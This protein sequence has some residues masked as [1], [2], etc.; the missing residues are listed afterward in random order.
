MSHYEDAV[1]ASRPLLYYALLPRWASGQ[2][3]ITDLTGQGFD[4]VWGTSTPTYAPSGIGDRGSGL[5]FVDNSGTRYIAIPAGFV[6]PAS[7]PISVEIW[8][9]VPVSATK[10]ATS[11]FSLRDADNP[12][13]QCHLPYND[14]TVYWDYGTNSTNRRLSFAGLSK[15]AS[16][17]WCHW[18]FTAQTGLMQIFLNGRL[19]TSVAHSDIPSVTLSGG[20]IGSSAAGAV[21]DTY[22]SDHF[23]VYKR[24]LAQ[25]EILEHYN[26]GLFK[27]HVVSFGRFLAATPTSIK[28]I[29]G[30]SKSSVKTVDGL[31]IDSVK[32]WVGLP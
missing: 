8:R 10:A 15:V 21:N 30:L 9:Y 16:G 13:C 4:A 25:E 12:R 19:L 27:T 14:D 32:T 3:T 18:V 23:A 5:N 20:R 29:D 17:R 31:A 22:S 11:A 26:A 24:V 28:T 2:A 7:S 6:F 1:L